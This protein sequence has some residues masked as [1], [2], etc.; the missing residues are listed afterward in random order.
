[1][2]VEQLA[3]YN[4]LEYLPDCYKIAEAAMLEAHTLAKSLGKRCV[5]AAIVIRK[6]SMRSF[7]RV[8]MAINQY[9][10]TLANSFTSSEA[11]LSW[12][13]DIAKLT[14]TLRILEENPN[15]RDVCLFGQYDAIA[16]TSILAL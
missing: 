15:W 12:T 10:S 7:S 4:V 16:A 9:R 3:Q 5:Q 11:R 6:H 14:A 8:F 1:M 2:K 13:N